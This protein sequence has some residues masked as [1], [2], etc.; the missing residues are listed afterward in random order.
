MISVSPTSVSLTNIVFAFNPHLGVVSATVAVTAVGSWTVTCNPWLKV[1]PSSGS[2]NGTVTI[3]VSPNA[4]DFLPRGDGINRNYWNT[5]YAV[6]TVTE[7]GGSALV[8]VSYKLG[9]GDEIEVQAPR[10]GNIRVEGD[11]FN[12]LTEDGGNIRLESDER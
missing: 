7:S 11:L 6:V 1:S 10:G 5:Y 9:F 8:Y 2:G 3:S 12:I 4:G